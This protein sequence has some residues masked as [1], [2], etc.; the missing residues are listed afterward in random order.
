MSVFGN[1]IRRADGVEE[2]V[3]DNRIYFESKN[4]SMFYDT[5]EKTLIGDYTCEILSDGTKPGITLT[6][7]VE[8]IQKILEKIYFFASVNGFDIELEDSRGNKRLAT[9]RILKMNENL[10]LHC[11]VS[12][13]PILKEKRWTVSEVKSTAKRIVEQLDERIYKKEE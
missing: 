6:I 9:I 10:T 5:I 11:C 13:M 4:G 7:D 8:K 3:E 12:L 1:V 2:R